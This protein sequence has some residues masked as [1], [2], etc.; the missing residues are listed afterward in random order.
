MQVQEDYS[1]GVIP[2]FNDQGVWYVFLINQFGRAGGVYW[3]LPKGHAEGGEASTDA[4]LRELS[5]ETGITL[6]R[7][8]DTKSYIQEYSF[9]YEDTIVNKKVI[10]YLGIAAAKTF[11]IQEDEVSDA[12][13][14]TFDK[15]KERL[16][17]EHAKEMLQAIEAELVHV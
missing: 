14:F 13:W 3:T 12:G 10:Y 4:A 8:I 1:Y 11:V 5:E 6:S 17:F 9:K 15:A 2:V 16:T 7:L